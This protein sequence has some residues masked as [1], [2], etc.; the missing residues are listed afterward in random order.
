MLLEYAPGVCYLMLPEY[1]PRELLSNYFSPLEQ[2]EARRLDNI[3]KQ[4][5]EVAERKRLDLEKRL[6]ALEQYVLLSTKEQEPNVVDQ[7][8]L[9]ELE[10]VI[11]TLTTIYDKLKGNPS[12]IHEDLEPPIEATQE[13]LEKTLDGKILNILLVEDSKMLQ[14]IFKRWWQKKGHNVF[15][16]SNGQE[17]VEAVKTRNFSI[18]FLDIEMPIKDGLT[19]A[20]EIRAY[21]IEK[22]SITSVPIIAVSGYTQKQYKEKALESGCNAFISKDQGYQFNDI[23]KIV[24]DYGG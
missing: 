17:A 8:I 23:Y 2:M 22:G 20:R 5:Y 16:A 11:D 9:D 15:V 12:D 14:E 24:L 7:D 13:P 1:A 21:E 18:I 6:A 10:N 19:T 3:F 4:R